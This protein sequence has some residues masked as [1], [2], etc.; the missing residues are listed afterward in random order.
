MKVLRWLDE[1]LEMS[2]CVVLMSA[3]TTI[4]FIQVVARRVFSHSLTWSEELARYLFLWLIYLAISYGAK[5]MKHIKIEAFL[6]VFPK[7]LRPCIIILGDILF[8]VFAVFIIYTSFVWVQ[9][10]IKL[11]QL[12]PALHVPMWVIYAAPFTGFTLTA[13]RQIQTLAYRFKQLKEGG[14]ND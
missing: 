13:I 6:A 11:G 12:S 9:R 1:K 10:Q 2:V 3:M 14:Q 5:I 7:K 4:M 8:F